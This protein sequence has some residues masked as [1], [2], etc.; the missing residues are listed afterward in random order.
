MIKGV[1]MLKN[2]FWKARGIKGLKV[3]VETSPSRK[4][5]GERGMEVM[6]KEDCCR[7]GGMHG[8]VDWALAI[9]R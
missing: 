2:I 5:S 9:S 1:E 6:F 8:Q 3:S 7:R 4:M